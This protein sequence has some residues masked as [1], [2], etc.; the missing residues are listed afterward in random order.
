MNEYIDNPFIVFDRYLI[1]FDLVSAC[2][3]KIKL[4]IEALKRVIISASF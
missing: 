3:L 1:V 4:Q 2:S